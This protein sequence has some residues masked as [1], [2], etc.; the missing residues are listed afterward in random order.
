MIFLGGFVVQYGLSGSDML[1]RSPGVRLTLL[2]NKTR[3]KH[4]CDLL[5]LKRVRWMLLV[6]WYSNSSTDSFL[7]L[8]ISVYILSVIPWQAL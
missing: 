2:A 8:D 5:I 4:L 6:A 3:T 7:R 1:P